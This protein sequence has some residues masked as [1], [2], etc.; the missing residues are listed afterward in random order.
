MPRK[1]ETPWQDPWRGWYQL[2]RWRKLRRAQ[3]RREPLLA[4][5]LS[6]GIVRAAEVA[7]HVVHHVGDWNSFLTGRLHAP[8]HAQSMHA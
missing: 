6:R 1:R 8:C 7:D 3:L 5:C 2:E 4:L